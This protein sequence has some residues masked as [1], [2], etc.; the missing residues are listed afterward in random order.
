[1]ALRSAAMGQRA[2]MLAAAGGGGG[3][4]TAEEGEEERTRAVTPDGT[5]I[6]GR[7]GSKRMRVA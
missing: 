2:A 7:G 1:M 3:Q 5:G 4:T 6:G